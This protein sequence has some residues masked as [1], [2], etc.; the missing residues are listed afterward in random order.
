MQPGRG[1]ALLD[2]ADGGPPQRFVW[3]PTDDADA[4]DELPEL[5]ARH[6]LRRWPDQPK[7][8]KLVGP[9]AP[10]TLLDTPVTPP[11]LRVLG[12]PEVA[13][14]AIDSH[15]VAMLRGGS[16]DPLDGHGLLYG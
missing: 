2:D 4:P 3:L 11:A 14:S 8:G 10:E 15:R 7:A 6:D 13:K 16:V 1:K 9:V 5:Q 12:V